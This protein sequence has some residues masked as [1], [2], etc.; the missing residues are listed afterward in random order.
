[1]YADVERL[2]ADAPPV[3]SPSDIFAL[4]KVFQARALCRLGKTAESEA[5][6][7]E[8]AHLIRPA[9]WNLQA[10]FAFARDKCAALTDRPLARTYA[11]QSADLAHG[12]D[13]FVEGRGLLDVGYLFFKDK[14]YDQAIA[15]LEKVR[16]ITDSGLLR[17]PTLGNLAESH[18]EMG[19]FKQ[20]IPLAEQAEKLAGQINNAWNQEAWLIDLGRAHLVLREYSQAEPY[21]A[22]ALTIAKSLKDT[23]GVARCLN[24]LTQLALRRHD[25]KTAERYWQEESSLV[26]RS[27]GTPYVSFDAAGI[28]MERKDF[29]KAESLLMGILKSKTNDSLA[30]T[31][32]RELGEVYWQEN[33]IVDADQT[34]REAIDRAE[35]I[36]KRLPPQYRMAFLDED[37][38]YDSYVRFLVAQGRSLDALKTAERGRAQILS[39]ALRDTRG[40]PPSLDVKAVQAALQKRNQIALAYSLT[41]EESFLWVITPMQ[42]EVK[43]LPSHKSLRPL[44]DAYKNEVIEHPR[45]ME[46]SS[47]GEELYKTLIQP[48]ESLIRKHSRVVI[49][50]SKILCLVN[51]EALIVPAVNG[52]RRHYW[53]D[54]VEVETASSLGLL[55][56]PK[57][58]G[59]KTAKS[60][61]E[62]LL[63]GAPLEADTAFPTL[64][65]AP[66]EMNR[67][68]SY[69]PGQETVISGK[70]AVPQAYRASNPGDYRFIHIDAHSA[71]SE[72][73]PMDSFVVLSPSG[74]S[75]KLF[76]HDITGTPL[77][78]DLVTL[79]ACYGAGTRWYQGEGIVGL[80][81]AFLRAGAHHVVASLWA[82]DDASTPQLMD[83]FYRELSKGKPV[84]EALRVAKLKMLH[85]PGPNSQPHYWAPLQLYTGS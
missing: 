29:P 58:E 43:Q 40:A 77:H 20:S 1:M 7:T 68:S 45:S 67:V 3:N 2:V 21:Y 18:A 66:K 51:F 38:F 5:A 14:K 39:E 26:V 80:G 9:E 82:V 78:A 50:P 76:A 16:P 23:D 37:P 52:T 13:G 41:D 62:L 57:R 17:E 24:N 73:N 36:T 28:A 10:E 31:T 60:K 55:A 32:Q 54:D 84:A 56:R 19:D 6:L 49:V 70:D 15:T 71:A 12:E 33:S 63:L 85:T 22:K 27:E 25:L 44:V 30:L 42:F 47:G 83:D 53:I 61:K 79:S 64:K 11:Q 34:F 46:D 59:V 72:L 8:A 65:Y 74:D 35:A 75:Y 69:F 4:R 48:A 81:W